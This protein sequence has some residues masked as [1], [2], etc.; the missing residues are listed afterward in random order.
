MEITLNTKLTDI[1]NHWGDGSDDAIWDNLDVID[2][3]LI[4]TSVVGQDWGYALDSVLR[5]HGE[6]ATVQHLR[7]DLLERVVED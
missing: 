2:D 7:D 5:A 3:S 1:A 4:D 6:D